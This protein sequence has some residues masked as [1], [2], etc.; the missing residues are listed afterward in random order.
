MPPRRG[1]FNADFEQNGN[2]RAT[3]G[4]FAVAGEAWAR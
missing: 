3:T 1:R 4:L 2:R